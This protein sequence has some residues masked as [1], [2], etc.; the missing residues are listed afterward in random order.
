M[1]L[2]GNK[3]T[4]IEQRK[5]ALSWSFFVLTGPEPERSV[6]YARDFSCRRVVRFVHIPRGC[7]ADADV[8]I[9]KDRCNGILRL[10]N[11]VA[12]SGYEAMPRR[13]D[14]RNARNAGRCGGKN[15]RGRVMQMHYL[16]PKFFEYPV[17]IS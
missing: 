8:P 17:E 5:S 14:A 15:S 7:V 2:Y 6:V 3:S 16:G 11:Q 1:V 13:H 12:R 9:A 4:Y 10:N